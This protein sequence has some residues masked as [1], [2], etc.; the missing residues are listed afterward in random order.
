MIGVLRFILASLVVLNHLWIPTAGR[1]D[2]HAV[3]AFY[4]ISGYLMTTVIN[5]TYGLTMVGGC[6]YLANRF[7]R[8][9]PPY[10][11]FAAISA[12]L[13]AIFPD[14]F[15]QTYDAIRLPD[16]L[17]DA[18]RN[19]TLI[20]RTWSPLRI[21]RPAWSLSVECFFYITMVA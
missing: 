2:A 20:D 7:L 6:K 17:Y 5:K 19:A 16:N 21:I 1:I 18:F 9:Y 12:G 4:V 13:L 11:P 15:G 8:I 10:W 3:I 14:T